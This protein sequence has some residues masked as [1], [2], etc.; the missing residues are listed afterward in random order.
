MLVGVPAGVGCG[1]R[2]TDRAPERVGQPLE[3]REPSA[4][5]SPR[6]PATIVAASVISGR[7]PAACSTTSTTRA[8]RALS[9]NVTS[10]VVTSTS[11]PPPSCAEKALAFTPMNW[12]LPLRTW[13]RDVISPPKMAFVAIIV[14][15]SSCRS[16]ASVT[17]P[18]C[19][20][21]AARATT[22]DVNGS[23]AYSRTGAPDCSSAAT[24]AATRGS[25]A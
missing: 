1:P 8:R 22:S 16:T 13:Q 9:S 12:G 6:P 15:P 14:A 24:S 17:T 5:P 4:S 11:P 3:E 25:V 10:R 23:D 21:T 2:G 18:A 7:P 20:R 19:R